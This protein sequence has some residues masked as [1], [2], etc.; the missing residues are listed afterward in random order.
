MHR[1]C[2]QGFGRAEVG[3]PHCGD[4]G[5]IARH[6]QLHGHCADRSGGAQDEQLL[7]GWT[8]SWL[9]TRTVA[10]PAAGDAAAVCQS[11]SAD[12]AP[13]PVRRAALDMFSP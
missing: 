12:L 11:T 10:S 7:P 2:A 1:D 8:S 13:K 6:G 4:D 9:R 3:A 5:D